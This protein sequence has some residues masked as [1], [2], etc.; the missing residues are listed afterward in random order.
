MKVVCAIGAGGSVMGLCGELDSTPEDG[1]LTIC[2]GV[3]V[4]G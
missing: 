2:R 3:R 1:P 4:L